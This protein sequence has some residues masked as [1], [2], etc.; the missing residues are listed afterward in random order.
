MKPVESIIILPSQEIFVTPALAFIRAAAA[1]CGFFEK[2]LNDIEVAAEEALTNVIKHAFEGHCDETFKISVRFTEADFIITI[3]EKGM[4]FS[5]DRIADY[6]PVKLENS[7][8]TNG[9]GVYLMKKNMDDVIFENLGREGKS[10]TLIKHI[11]AGHAKRT[12]E[13]YDNEVLVK[14]GPDAASDS[15][16]YEIRLFRPEDALEISRCAYKAYGYTY[17]PYIYYLE[18]IIEMNRDGKLC[19]FI[20]AGKNTGEIMG[21]VAFKYKNA[22]DRIAEIGVAF[23]KPEYRKAGILKAMTI[24]CHE[25]ALELKLFGLFGR[26]VT[27]HVASQRALEALGYAACGIFFGLFPDD[28]DFKALTG[29]IRQK[30]SGLLLYRTISEE[31]ERTIYVPARHKAKIS[32]IFAALRIA[33]RIDESEAGPSSGKSEIN[34][35]SVPVLNIADVEVLSIGNDIMHELKSIVH[36]LCLKHIDAI[37]LHIG[38]EDPKAAFVARECEQS[39]FF[40]SGVL[41]F[42][43]NNKHEFILQYMNNLAIDFD[44]IKPYSQ[45]GIEILNYVRT[46]DPDEINRGDK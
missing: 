18:K 38:M 22:G 6:D 1:S 30:E 10:L 39:G 13:N 37:F 8:N 45:G 14:S 31:D 4:P 9:L 11:T 32:D 16:L 27:S 20:A 17:E 5:P 41:P 40:F 19:S 25:K 44:I 42:G 36:D 34:V 3:Y 12:L 35:N 15:A 26:A 2:A 33:V 23:V 46:F 21:H 24:F 7:L 28:V 43:L 29:K